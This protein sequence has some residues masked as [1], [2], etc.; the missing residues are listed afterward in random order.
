MHSE[1]QE[2]STLYNEQNL[3]KDDKQAYADQ[4]Y[5]K[6]LGKEYMFPEFLKSDVVNGVPNTARACP[7]AWKNARQT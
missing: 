3:D 7:K 6:F 1:K 4:F 2:R 5:E